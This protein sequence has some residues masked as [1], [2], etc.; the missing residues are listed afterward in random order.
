MRIIDLS[1]RSAGDTESE[2]EEG[3]ISREREWARVGAEEGEGGSGKMKCDICKDDFPDDEL[4]EADI[5]TCDDDGNICEGPKSHVCYMCR[6]LIVA[7]G[8][9]NQS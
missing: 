2:A 1:V 9:E 8:I 6:T 3:S 5:M 7:V 4:V